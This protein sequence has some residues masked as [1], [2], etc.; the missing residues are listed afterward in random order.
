MGEVKSI[1]YKPSPLVQGGLEIPME[2]TVQWEDE[3]AMEILRRK[4]EEV[5]YPLGEMDQYEDKSK[6]ILNPI[7]K[8]ELSVS[9]SEALI[10]EL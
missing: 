6:D 9:D 7:L 1:K 10:V 5:N 3:Q 8:E 2:V 4:T